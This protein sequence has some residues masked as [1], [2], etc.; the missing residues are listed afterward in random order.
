MRVE[1]T[2]EGRIDLFESAAYY[3]SR[4]PGLGL[5]FRD[6]IAEVL[7]N[8]CGAP[9]LWRERAEGYRRINCPVFTHYV[10]YVIREETLIVVAIAHG[11]RQPGFWH[12]R[13]QDGPSDGDG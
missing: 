6:E 1:F 7:K 2:S 12:E 8:A 11:H 13:L 5:R 10:A 3:E 9:Y 4:E